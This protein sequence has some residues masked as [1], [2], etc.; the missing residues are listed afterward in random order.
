MVMEEKVEEVDVKSST[1][2]AHMDR[3]AEVVKAINRRLG[4]AIH[5]CL[6]LPI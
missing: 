3:A 6:Q 1:A 5:R 4:T 2:L